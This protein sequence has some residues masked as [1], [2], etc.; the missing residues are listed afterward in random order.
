MPTASLPELLSLPA[1]ERAELAIALWD[2]LSDAQRQSELSLTAE[3]SAELDRRWAQHLA[4][5]ETA[6][7]WGD[8]RRR[9]GGGG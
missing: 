5:P 4:S 9:L 2:S 1:K 7:A 6:L 3:Q 8:V